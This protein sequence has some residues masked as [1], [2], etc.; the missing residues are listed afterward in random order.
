M[1]VDNIQLTNYDREPIHSP[2]SIQP[3]GLFLVLSEPDLE[4]LYISNNT[5]NLLGMPAQKYLEQHLSVLLEPEQ[6]AAIEGCLQ[7]NFENINPLKL[8]VSSHGRICLFNGIIHRSPQ[9]DLILELEPC[10]CEGSTGFYDFYSLTRNAL[11]QMQQVSNL[12]EL[13]AAI[14]KEVRKMTGFD[15]VMV[16]RFDEKSCGEVIAEDKL[17]Q[18]EPYLGLRYPDFDIPPHAR[19][20]YTLNPLRLIAD[21]NYQPV[22]IIS[23]NQNFQSPIQNPKSKIQNFQSPIQNPKSK[24][25]NPLDLT[26]SVLRSVS[27]C[28]IQYL[29]NMGVGAS[30]S[31]SLVKD[32]KLWGLIACHHQTPRFV[33]YE[34]RTACEFLG[35]VMSLELASK[36]ENENLEYKL[37][38]KFSQ[39]KFIDTV[40]KSQDFA[41]ALFQDRV[42]LL[43]LVNAEGA[44]VCT[45]GHLTLIGKTPS[46]T[47]IHDLM[48]WLG[49]K[50]QNYLFVTDSLSNL[51]P[52]AVDFKD[53]ASGLLALS[54]ARIRN[55]YVLWF[56]PERLQYVNWAGNPQPVKTVA[57]D[58][59]LTLCPRKSFELWQEQVNGT[60]LPWQSYEIDGAIELRSAIVG[61]VLR[62][63]DELA[64][65]NLELERSN[66][67]LD[68][69]AYIASHDLKEPLRGIHNY[70]TFLLEDYAKIL[71][72][73]GVSKLETLV[74]LTKR[75]EDLI[76]SL[77]HF[78]RLGRQELNVELIDFN[79]LVQNVSE[80][81]CMSLGNSHINIRIPKPLPVIRGDRI[82]LEEVLINLMSNGFK[83][84]ENPEKWVEIGYLDSLNEQK[85][86]LWTFYVKD[87][88]I[89]IREKHLETIFR[90][91]KRLHAP[92]KYAGG[93]GAGLTIVKKIIE[94]HDGKIWVESADGQGSTFYFTLP[95]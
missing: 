26:Y 35:K 53:V 23:K 62:K 93:T 92:G 44:V 28:H 13:S 57:P 86:P 10:N 90:I 55:N 25:Q 39:T 37:Q 16:Y 66:N 49:D 33:S 17:E 47:A 60:S 27:T 76:N 85:P 78:S 79:E 38:L 42:S 72:G 14:V 61:I 82:L 46:E 83:Y 15:R 6:I 75:M 64:A 34:I 40:A 59:S 41:D 5:E 50:F 67:E 89:G 2:G 21:V 3:H 91:F 29:K 9:N 43:K 18:I 52:K 36:E 71:D 65:I 70:S 7:G 32:G 87:N 80:I 1:P 58:G 68:A 8:A 73:E 22:T 51:Y 84:N 63:A 31:I 48:S 45:D 30:M 69:F 20:L 19:Y 24:I 74:R 4:I 54:I 56:R 95:K 11:T 94:R 88:G 77:L 12:S 81:F